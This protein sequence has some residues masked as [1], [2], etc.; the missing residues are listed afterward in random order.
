MTFHCSY[1]F[2]SALQAYAIQEAI[3][4]LGHSVHLIDYRSNNWEQYRLIDPKH[5]RKTIRTLRRFKRF[6]SREVAFKKFAAQRFQLTRRFDWRNEKK[7]E[8]LQRE[9]DCFVCGSDQI[10]NLDCTQG[11]VEPFFLSFAGDKRRVAYAPSLAHTSFRPENFDKGKVAKLLSKFD[12]LSV[13]EGETVPLFQPLVNKKIEVTLDPTLL[14]DADA[15]AGMANAYIKEGPYIFT[16][17]LRECP[18]LIESAT[19]MAN[20]GS[21]IYY[22]SEKDLHIP[23]SVNLFGAGPEEFVSLIAHADAVLT[24]SFHATVFSIL[25]HRP[26][27]VFATDESASRMHNLLGKLGILKR[28]VAD[29]DASPVADENWNEVD[30]RLSDLRKGSWDYLRRALS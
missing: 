10:W 20:E 2:G 22:I 23:N 1:N 27:R 6:W 28:S 16:Y 3:S 14:L 15:Y 12:Y 29:V 19:A 18:E 5:P 24:N 13:R 4:K 30:R 26:F 25:F 17:L 21:Y 8:V 9:N 7:L 11:V